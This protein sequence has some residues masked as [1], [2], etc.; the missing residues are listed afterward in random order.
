MIEIPSAIRRLTVLLTIFAILGATP[1]YAAP[2]VCDCSC[3]HHASGM[4]SVMADT[5]DYGVPCKKLTP[6]CMKLVGCIDLP[7]ACERPAAASKSAFNTR[8][9]YAWPT[10]VKPTFPR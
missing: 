3:T 1:M 10:S 4:Q 2:L 9:V 8:V 7:A 5:S 6:D